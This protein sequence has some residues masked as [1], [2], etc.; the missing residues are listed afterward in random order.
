[1]ATSQRI[2]LNDDTELEGHIL[3]NGDGRKIFVYLTG[4]VSLLTGITMFSD[5]AKTRTIRMISYGQEY[6][7]QGYTVLD[8]ASREYGNC[9]LVM[10][11][12]D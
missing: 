10:S 1:M 3:D 12:G 8:S 11:K 7:Y 2:I 6:T 9:N 4:G 5:P